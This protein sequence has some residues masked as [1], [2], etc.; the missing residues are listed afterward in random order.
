MSNPIKVQFIVKWSLVL[1]AVPASVLALAMLIVGLTFG[2]N[3]WRPDRP[4]AII[5]WLALVFFPAFIAFA[6]ASKGSPRRF[7]ILSAIAWLFVAFWLFENFFWKPW[8][9]GGSW[10]W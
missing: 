10:G 8:E 2:A 6:L 7:Y 9:Y 3:L 5:I 4:Y 1:L